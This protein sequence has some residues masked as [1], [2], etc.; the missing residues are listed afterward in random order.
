MSESKVILV[1]YSGHGLA[2]ADSIK[3]QNS[4][5]LI[6]YI[7][8]QPKEFN[9]F[10]LDYFGSDN[11]DVFLRIKNNQFKVILG[12]GD[13]VLR[14]KIFNQY[15]SEKI[16]FINAID[17]TSNLSKYIT[18][19]IG[20]FFSRNTIVN[21]FSTI[22]NNC[23]LNSGCIIEHECFIESHVHIAPGAVLC[24]NVKVGAHSFIGANSTIKQGISIGKN[25]IVGAGSVVI[26][27]IPDYEIWV[28]NPAKKISNV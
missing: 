25:V 22:S 21:S 4:H 19:G 17:S 13:N 12:I 9:P 28:G 15:N 11:P 27:D 26:N 1:G 5:Q 24:G 2:L 3:E 8:Q 16:S 6:G 23:I 10:K 7:D 20:N 18:C 14:S